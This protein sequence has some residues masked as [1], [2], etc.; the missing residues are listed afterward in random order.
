MSLSARCIFKVVGAAAQ[1]APTPGT[2]VRWF[3]S[4]SW[5]SCLDGQQCG[6]HRKQGF[7]RG[8]VDGEFH[9]GVTLSLT[10]SFRGP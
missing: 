9:L 6:E 3:C 8:G 2:G 5:E 7:P 4:Q 10:S 1:Q